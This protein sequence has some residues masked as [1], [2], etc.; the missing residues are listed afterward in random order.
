MLIIEKKIF[1]D[2]WNEM[3]ITIKVFVLLV[4]HCSAYVFID[5]VCRYICRNRF[6]SLMPKVLV[7]DIYLSL[8]LYTAIRPRGHFW[9]VC[10]VELGYDLVSDFL[11]FFRYCTTPSRGLRAGGLRLKATVQKV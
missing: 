11:S 2:T 3:T 1:D 9:Q 6:F 4:Y 7:L 8:S 5:S 10:A